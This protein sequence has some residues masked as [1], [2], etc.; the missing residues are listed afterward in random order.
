MEIKVSLL[1]SYEDQNKNKTRNFRAETKDRI[2]Y[3][4]I[5]EQ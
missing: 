4:I 2:A 1:R 3:Q 5:R